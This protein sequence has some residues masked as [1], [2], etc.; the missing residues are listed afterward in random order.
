VPSREPPCPLL[1][2][3]A[4]GQEVEA[5]TAGV[6]DGVVDSSP[7]ADH[8]ALGNALLLVPLALQ[9]PHLRLNAAASEFDAGEP[10]KTSGRS[11][12]PCGSGC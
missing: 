4:G 10:I 3:A 8:L 12:R 9:I 1:G 2:P 7:D 6:I 5:V 11:C